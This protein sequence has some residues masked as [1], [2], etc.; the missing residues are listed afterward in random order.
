MNTVTTKNTEQTAKGWIFY[1][2][3]CRLCLGLAR[4]WEA[5][6]ARRQFGLAPLEAPWVRE[7]LGVHGRDLL[8]EMRMLTPD[9][10]VFCGAE[11]I[12]ELARA[13]WWARW[14]ARVAQVPSGLKLLRSAYAWVAARRHCGTGACATSIQEPVRGLAVPS[15]I[16]RPRRCGLQVR[17]PYQ[18]LSDSPL[19]V[20][21]A[22][23]VCATWNAPAWLAM[24]SLAGALFF[25]LKY[26]TNWMLRA[27]YQATN[28][29]FLYLLGVYVLVFWKGG[30][31]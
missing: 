23:A 19:V 4:R 17:A 21:S 30:T 29:V 15:T 25:G 11:A 12:V 31:P 24:W 13:F 18:F 10:R 1:D 3:D 7:R 9:G 6:L 5:G 26:L 28:L 27:G 2:G 16:D 20:L 22:I 8:R 14:L